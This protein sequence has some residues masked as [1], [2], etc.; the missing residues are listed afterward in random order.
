MNF[1]L[2]KL[3]SKLLSLVLVFITVTIVFVSTIG[4]LKPASEF[5]W[6]DTLGEGGITLMTL[7]W[8]FFTL[9][10]RPAGKV[11]VLLII[12]LL[13][14]HVSMLLDLLDE[15]YRYPENHAWLTAYESVPAPIGMILLSIGLYHW[16]KEQLRVNEQLRTRERVYREHGLMDYITGLYS[17]EYMKQQIQQELTAIASQSGGQQKAAFS[18]LMLD[19]DEFDSFNLRYGDVRGDQ[20]LREISELI[21]YE[22]RATDL[23][24]R[25]AGDRFIVLLPETSLEDATQTAEELTQALEARSFQPLE[26]GS[27]FNCKVSIC[28]QLAQSDSQADNLLSQLNEKMESMKLNKKTRFAA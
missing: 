5:E 15:F 9:I 2:L 27:S 21:M 28:A 1:K 14:M 19:I 4:E 17:A 16:H 10:S 25:Y 18:L 8:I 11:T 7:V 12:G 6:S 20:F 22:L 26:Q 24:S 13:F 3:H 23:V